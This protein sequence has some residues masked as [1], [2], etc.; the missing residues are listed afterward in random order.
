MYT[1]VLMLGVGLAILASAVVINLAILD[2]ITFAD[3]RETL[4]KG[5][6]VVAVSTIAVLLLL[7]L[8]RIGRRS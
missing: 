3:V 2:I 4:G 7:A 8:G 5:L 1:R 6:S